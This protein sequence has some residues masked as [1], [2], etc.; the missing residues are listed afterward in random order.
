MQLLFYSLRVDTRVGFDPQ[1]FLAAG[2]SSA[3]KRPASAKNGASN[4]TTASM[5]SGKTK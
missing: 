5:M 2:C 3:Y 1:F 4:N